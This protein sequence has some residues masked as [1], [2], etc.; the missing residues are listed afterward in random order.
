MKKAVKFT[1]HSLFILEQL[2]KN[3]IVIRNFDCTNERSKNKKALLFRLM[4]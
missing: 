3:M 1:F 2:I 4:L